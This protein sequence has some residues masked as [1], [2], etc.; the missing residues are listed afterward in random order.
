MA[1]F[2]PTPEKVA[3]WV[4]KKNVNKLIGALTS[5]DAM[6]RRK[7]AEGLGMIGGHEVLQFCKKNARNENKQV[8]W[9]ITQILGMIGTPEAIQ[10]MDSV[11]DPTDAVR[12]S[13]KAKGK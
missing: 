1:L 13:A 8:R 10:V 9:A 6:V 5:E 12:R 11:M 7:S 4:D 2:G 3:K